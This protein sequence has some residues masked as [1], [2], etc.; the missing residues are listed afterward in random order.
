MSKRGESPLAHDGWTKWTGKKR[1]RGWRGKVW[2]FCGHTTGAGLPARAL[3]DDVEIIDKAYEHYLKSHGTHY[4]IAYDGSIIQVANEDMQANGVGMSDQ[5]AAVESDS[6]ISHFGKILVQ[7]PWIKESFHGNTIAM[8][9]WLGRWPDMVTPLDLYPSKYANSCYI[10]C[11]MP[12][13]VFWYDDMLQIEEEPHRPGLRFTTAQHNS[14]IKLAIDIADRNKFPEGWWHGTG[15]LVGHEDL[16][17]ITRGTKDGTWD[18][19][20]LRED[21]WF[22]WDYVKEEIEKVYKQ[23]ANAL[24]ILDEATEAVKSLDIGP[25]SEEIVAKAFIEWLKKV[26]RIK[27]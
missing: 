7:G 10:H 22:D 18:P 26:F 11:E 19:G 15:R 16:S 23:R 4:T 25:A 27:W 6:L 12:P 9:K 13:C 17:P 3:E 24:K 21:P 5:I 20:Y 14:F 2:G 8:S 1:P